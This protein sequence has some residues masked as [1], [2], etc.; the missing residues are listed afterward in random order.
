M[1][2]KAEEKKPCS[3][4]KYNFRCSFSWVKLILK[5]KEEESLVVKAVPD[6][7]VAI[8]EVF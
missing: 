6:F 1:E 3:S 2:I 4:T 8:A 7:C 5:L